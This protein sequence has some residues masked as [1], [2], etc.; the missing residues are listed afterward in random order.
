MLKKLKAKPSTLILIGTLVLLIILNPTSN[1][2]KNAVAANEWQK[3]QIGRTGYFVIFSTFKA[4]YESY[5]ESPTVKGLLDKYSH[6]T[7]YLGLF[8][9]F[10]EIKDEKKYLYSIDK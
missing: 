8:K 1:D 5:E 6:K 3:I 9:N 2:L 7:T 4:S 10:I